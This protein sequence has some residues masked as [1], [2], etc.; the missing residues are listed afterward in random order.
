MLCEEDHGQ[1]HSIY[2]GYKPDPLFEP[3]L[4]SPTQ[5]AGIVQHSVSEELSFPSNHVSQVFEGEMGILRVLVDEYPASL[6]CM[7]PHFSDESK[8]AEAGL[9]CKLSSGA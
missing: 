6:Y 4:S 5:A 3:V 7:P 2:Y 1:S 9:L 8:V